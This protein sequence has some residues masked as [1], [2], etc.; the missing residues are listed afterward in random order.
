MIKK[1]QIPKIIIII[2]DS[3]VVS[4]TDSK[5][6]RIVSAKICRIM[7]RKHFFI[8]L[9]FRD[10]L[11][12]QVSKGE[13]PTTAARLARAFGLLGNIGAKYVFCFGEIDIRCHLADPEKNTGFINSYIL[14]CIKLV[15]AKP[16]DVMFL[17][18]TP[19]SDFYLDHPS[20]PRS[21]N[22]NE[23]VRAHNDYCAE[24][25]D[26]AISNF[27]RYINSQS[28][29]V[30]GHGG[31]RRELTEDGCHLNSKGAA[32]IRNIVSNCLN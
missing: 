24:L 15:K 13:F 9:W 2:G 12:F 8:S 23:R 18:P 1:F 14:N 25:E 5:Y 11:A 4:L 22:L 32:I 16:K 20:F 28:A 7:G 21:G 31:L 26:G 29:L 10:T 6:E 30:D 19:P 27:C 17:T 3:H